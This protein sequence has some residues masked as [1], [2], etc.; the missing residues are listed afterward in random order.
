MSFETIIADNRPRRQATGIN[1]R[2]EN[3]FILPAL[4]KNRNGSKD[5][6]CRRFCVLMDIFSRIFQISNDD[7]ANSDDGADGNLDSIQLSG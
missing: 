3:Q 6:L 4:S 1:I 2:Q 7:S 5:F